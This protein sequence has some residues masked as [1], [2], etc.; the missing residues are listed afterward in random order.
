VC[1]WEQ[2][3]TPF[4]QNGRNR[5]NKE[6]LITW[7]EVY[8]VIKIQRNFVCENNL[9][10]RGYIQKFPDWVDNEINNNNN[11]HSLR[12][13][14]RGCRGR[15]H[16]TDSQGGDA[17]ASGGEEPGHLQFSLRAASPE[18]FG[19]TL[20][21]TLLWESYILK[22]LNYKFTCFI[23]VWNLVTRPEVRSWL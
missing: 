21:F 12:S 15:T 3:F 18:T 23:W 9:N 14:T 2:D 7:F 17:I 5:N 10:I 1:L 22:Y 6:N 20:V 13:G 16:W 19:Y 11:K 8:M 4:Q